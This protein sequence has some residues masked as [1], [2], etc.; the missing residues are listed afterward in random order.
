MRHVDHTTV[1]ER[2]PWNSEIVRQDGDGVSE[3]QSVSHEYLRK[4]C[5][6]FANQWSEKSKIL[7]ELCETSLRG[8]ALGEEIRE[9]LQDNALSL[10]GGQQQRLCIARAIASAANH[11]GN[12]RSA[13]RAN[14]TTR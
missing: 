8:G 7:Q 6:S 1:S 9:R 11:S 2:F 4:R 3:T 5:L 13:G 10:S 14:E 12:S